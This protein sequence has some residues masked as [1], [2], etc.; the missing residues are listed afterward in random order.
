MTETKRLLDRLGWR[1]PYVA[2][3]LGRSVSTVQDW[4]SGV[5][6]RGNPCQTPDD[7]LDWLRRCVRAIEAIPVPVR[8]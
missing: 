5:N 8:A 7:V 3:L 2:R 1:A 4:V 6:S